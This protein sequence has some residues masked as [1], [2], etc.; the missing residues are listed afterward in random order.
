MQLKK[1][2][3]LEINYYRGLFFNLSLVFVLGLLMMAFEW[4]V[5]T[6]DKIDLTT[7]GIINNLQS[8]DSQIVI[9]KNWQEDVLIQT[10]LD[11]K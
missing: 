1:N 10:D 8:I 2:P 7:Q 9:D 3:K 5:E 11:V 6:V 4:R